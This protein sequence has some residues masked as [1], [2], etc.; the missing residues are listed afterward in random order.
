M[1]A[2]RAPAP[3][4]HSLFRRLRDLL[5]WEENYNRGSLDAIRI[6]VL[7]FGFNGRLATRGSTVMAG[8][9][10]LKV[11]RLLEDEGAS[12][13][14]GEGLRL[15][16][17]G[18][19]SVLV[20]P[21]DHLTE[22]QAAAFAIADNRTRD[23]AKTDDEVLAAHLSRL[24]AEDAALMAATG[25]NQADLDKMLAALEPKDETKGRITISPELL[26]RQDYMVILFDND[27][28]WQALTDALALETV[29]SAPVYGRTMEG[30]RGRARV[31]PARRII[32]AL[33]LG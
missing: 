3:E 31:L 23:L 8:N 18:A 2:K 16:D 10:A 29:V 1:P 12:F 13:P 4:Q 17:D 22:A 7:T 25:Y 14:G 33:G 6:S 19:W 5:P 28:D 20:T 30:S 21:L 26:E 32:D 15:E 9:H 27:L 24:A 11:L